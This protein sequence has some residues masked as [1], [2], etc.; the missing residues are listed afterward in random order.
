MHDARPMYGPHWPCIGAFP[1]NSQ[2][3][4]SDET[5]SIL[6]R[7]SRHR[8]GGCGARREQQFVQFGILGRQQEHILE[9]RPEQRQLQDRYLKPSETPPRAA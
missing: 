9:F 4:L 2:K 1:I 6:R 5:N 7:C 8:R 3:D